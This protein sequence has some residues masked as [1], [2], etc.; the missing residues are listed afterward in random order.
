MRKLRTLTLEKVLKDIC[1]VTSV[2]KRLKTADLTL[3]NAW[4]LFRGLLEIRPSFGRYFPKDADITQSV[5][6]D[7]AVAKV[8]DSKSA[9][10]T[11]NEAAVLFR[12]SP[13]SVTERTLKPRKVVTQAP[14]YVLL[15]AISPIYNG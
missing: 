9:S 6:F 7:A 4:V 12:C 10:L 2:S 15:E 8:L 1:E 14:S 3:L 11:D 5:V 13:V